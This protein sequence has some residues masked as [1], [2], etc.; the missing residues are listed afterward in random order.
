MKETAP[1]A[2]EQK[3]LVVQSRGCRVMIREDERE[4]AGVWYPE[5]KIIASAL[6]EEQARA[7]AYF[8]DRSVNMSRMQ[9]LVA[10][11]NKLNPSKPVKKFATVA[12]GEKRVAELKGGK[13]GATAPAKKAAAKKAPAKSAGKKAP[14]AAKIESDAK[15]TI[16]AENPSHRMNEGSARAALYARI[17]E[18]GGK[19]VPVAKLAADDRGTLSQLV[20]LGWAKVA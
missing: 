11:Y 4:K 7:A 2:S 3:F 12:A 16:V 9:E 15:V 8:T 17:K 19:S 14:A 6:T 18:L 10:E 5:G 13:K 20:R 1:S